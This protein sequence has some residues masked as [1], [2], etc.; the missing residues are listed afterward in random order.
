LDE[1]SLVQIVKPLIKEAGNMLQECKSTIRALDPDSSIAASAKA[2]SSAHEATLE[3]YQLAD[4]L[5]QLTQTV[6]TTID[7]GRQRIADMPHAKK[8][9]NP[10]WALLSEP[11][12]QIIAAVGLLL[13]GI[14]GL[15]NQLLSGLGLGG[16]VRGLLGGLGIYN[17]MNS[18]GLGDKL[19]IGS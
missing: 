8:K 7:K 6:S 14:L 5:K 12:F 3:E 13:S 18:F 1:E 15:V 11:L 4:T 16:L 10:L 19:G 17:L 9:L 2:H